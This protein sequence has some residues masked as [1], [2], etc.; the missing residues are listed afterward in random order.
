VSTLDGREATRKAAAV[1]A[2]VRTAGCVVAVG[3]F[4]RTALA[5][6]RCAIEGKKPTAFLVDVTPAGAARISVYVSDA[7]VTV[8]PQ[9]VDAPPRVHVR[10]AL[11][12]DA[13]VPPERLPL[14]TLDGV[15]AINANVHLARDLGGFAGGIVLRKARGGQ[16]EADVALGEV[17]LRGLLLRCQALT[18]DEVKPAE[19]RREHDEDGGERFVSRNKTL[20]LR[21]YP[22]RGSQIDIEL[23][24]RLD[25]IDFRHTQTEGAWW[26]I[27]HAWPDG[28][29]LDGWVQ[30]AD[31]E[32]HRRGALHD[33]HGF[34]PPVPIGCKRA[35]VARGSERIGKATIAPGTK[36]YAARDTSPWATTRITEPVSV[37]YLPRDEWAEIVTVPGLVGGA[38][39]PQ[40]STALDDAW[41]PRAAIKLVDAP[42][43]PAPA[44]AP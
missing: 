34:E 17:K 23:G 7:Q 24:A 27:S 36:V 42:P 32:P 18:L 9:S 4:T 1:I 25:A 20:R 2:L 33:D 43:E 6:K 16:V 21:G 40:R 3:L 37:R 29:S 12:F 22:N 5:D 11:E 38:E 19:L 15:D 14:R 30:K 26:R 39:C 10:G 8:F 28:T 44:P 31:L 41:V 13:T 35:P